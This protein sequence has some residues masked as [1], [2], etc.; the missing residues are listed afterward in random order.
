MPPRV[1][2]G[3]SARPGKQPLQV[4]S[5]RPPKDP[6]IWTRSPR[7]GAARH[8]ASWG[9]ARSGI[10]SHPPNRSLVAGPPCTLSFRLCL[11][12]VPGA[13]TGGP[14]Q[15]G[16]LLRPSRGLGARETP[17]AGLGPITRTRCLSGFPSSHQGAG[18]SQSP[19]PAL[20]SRTRRGF[21]THT[22]H[23]GP[24]VREAAQR[25][26]GLSDPE[27]ARLRERRAPSHCCPMRPGRPHLLRTSSP[28][29]CSEAWQGFQLCP[30]TVPRITESKIGRAS[31]RER[32]SSPV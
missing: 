29:L 9:G 1:P 5:P 19:E 13:W 32:V 12:L 6:K 8:C 20:S 24:Q 17:Q 23:D 11:P 15:E 31:C 16:T 3:P 18:G 27:S 2:R 14:A 21:H 7:P 26:N 28:P 22:V 30:K 10:P 25:T 4:P